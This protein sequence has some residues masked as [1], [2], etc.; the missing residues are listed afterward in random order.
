M[1]ATNSSV[2]LTCPQCTQLLPVAEGVRIVK[3]PTC[4][5]RS[6][7]AGE[8]GIR[9]WQVLR[10]VERQKAMEEVEGFFSGFR[11]AGDLKRTAQVKELFL[12][13]LPYWRV[14]AFVSGWIFGRERRDKDSTRPVEIEKAE[15]MIWNDAAVDVSEF[16]VHRVAMGDKELELYDSERLHAEG[17]VFQPSESHTDAVREAETLFTYRAKAGNLKERYFEKVHFLRRRLSLVY[18]PLWVARYDYKG[19]HYQVVV[20]GA[21]GEVLYGKAPGNSWFRAA[22]LVAGMAIGN[23]LLVNG[24]I[25]ALWFG[26][27]SDG[28]EFLATLLLPVILG[29]GL[30]VGG[31]QAF[32]YGEEVESRADTAKKEQGGADGENLWQMGRE[33]LSELELK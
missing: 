16:G 23:F 2:G 1:S 22:A 15:D 5:S 4:N 30:I 33:L 9:R 32:R 13:Y 10:R 3:C 18:Y 6:L 8:R 12:V 14:Q 19:R 27:G 26:S 7:V 24:T 31:Y 20:D 25:F 29:I 17:L 28:E 21:K 11:K